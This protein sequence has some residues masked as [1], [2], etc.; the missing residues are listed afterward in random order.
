[1]IHNEQIDYTGKGGRETEQSSCGAN[2]L[3]NVRQ[4]ARQREMENP[5][6]NINA[7]K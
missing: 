1:M 5:R 3:R 2:G 4:I 6:C 7:A